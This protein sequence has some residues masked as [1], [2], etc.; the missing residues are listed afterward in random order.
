VDQG[1]S[2]ST[3]FRMFYFGTKIFFCIHWQVTCMCKVNCRLF[4]NGWTEG[5]TQNLSQDGLCP[6]QDLNWV[7]P[8]WVRSINHHLRSPC[9]QS[10]H[11]CR[12]HVRA[13]LGNQ[14]WPCAGMRWISNVTMVFQCR[15]MQPKLTSLL[16]V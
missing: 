16:W 3:K 5:K 1:Q 4:N 11:V 6:N 8:K 15:H 9:D 12:L 2:Q 14:A 7:L 13:L 10:S